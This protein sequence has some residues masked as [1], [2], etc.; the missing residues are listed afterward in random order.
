MNNDEMEEYTGNPSEDY[1]T[2]ELVTLR[3]ELKKVNNN[4]LTFK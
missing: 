2:T 3:N 4:F 1:E